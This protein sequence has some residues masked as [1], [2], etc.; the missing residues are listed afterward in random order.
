MYAVSDRFL[1]VARRGGTSIS[2]VEVWRDGAIVPLDTDTSTVPILDGSVTDDATRPGIRRSL[3]LTTTSDLWNELNTPGTLLKPFRGWRYID[4]STE[5]AALGVFAVDATRR[6]Y[7]HS[8]TDAM[9]LTCPDLW[10]RVQRSRFEA[11][12][13]ASGNAVTQ[14]VS[15]VT[16]C[17]TDAPDTEVTA[18][19]SVSVTDQVYDRDRSQ[20]IV[21]MA[22]AAAFDI[23]FG[24]DGQVVARPIPSV[25]DPIAWTANT[26]ELGVLISASRERSVQRVYN[27]VVVSGQDVD[28]APPFTPVVRADTDPASPT[29]VGD[30]T[31]PGM[32]RIPYFYSSPLL[33][34]TAQ[35]NA[36]AA[37]IYARVRLPAVQLA[38]TQSVN[39]ALETGDVVRVALPDGDNERHLIE[40]V[41]TSLTVDGVQSITARS[42]RS[43]DDGGD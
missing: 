16:E 13:V 31:N 28:G 40:R 41:E 4:G 9:T 22:K 19:S 30:A 34:T 37:T 17:F 35:A 32:G 42:T 6:V 29:Y 18:T 7:E 3:T 15:W 21:D 25:D 23:S 11:P 2:K 39:P 24:S 12:R 43:E 38:F 36:A 33:L 20:A 8:A 26:G 1:Q 10:A 14:A 27:V 5:Y